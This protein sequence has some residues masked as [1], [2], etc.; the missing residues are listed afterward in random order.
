[1]I[2]S[3]NFFVLKRN[4]LISSRWINSA[5]IICK[6]FIAEQKHQKSNMNIDESYSQSFHDY[7]R[8][9]DICLQWKVIKV[10]VKII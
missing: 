5:D 10:T 3:A 6:K 1:M 2:I 4:V 8:W 7:V 9:N